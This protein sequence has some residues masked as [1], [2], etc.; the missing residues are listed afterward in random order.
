MIFA[1]KKKAELLVPVGS[2]ESCLAAIHNGADSIYFG[3]SGFNARGRAKDFSLQ[4]TQ[5]IIEL[6]HL[7]GVKSYL[8]FN[9]LIFENEL[10]AARELLLSFKI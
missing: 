5:E 7:Y 4:E 8:A 9:V 10:A 6:C 2:F 1:M 3:V